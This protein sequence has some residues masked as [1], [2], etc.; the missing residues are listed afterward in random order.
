MMDEQQDVLQGGESLLGAEVKCLQL[1]QQ[2]FNEGENSTVLIANTYWLRIM[3]AC[4]ESSPAP[5][6]PEALPAEG[7]HIDLTEDLAQQLEDII[8]TYQAAEIPAE[9]EDAEEVTAVKEA[10]ARKDQKL[11]KKMLKNLG[12]EAM[13]LMQSLNKLNTP[14][15]KLEAIIKK[16]AELLEEHRSDQKQLKV[17]QKKLLQVMKEKDQLQSEHSRAVLARSKLEGLCR[18]LQRHNKTL[19]EETLQRCR[20]DDL[21]R[22]EIT[23][24][25]QGTLSEIQAQIEEH[26]SRNTKLC[27]ENSALAEKLKGLISQYDQREAPV[28]PEQENETALGV[29]AT[30]KFTEIVFQNLEKVFKH[31]DLK[32]KLL[33]T[34]L[35][36]AN[37]ILKEAEEKH[38]LEKELLLKQTVEYKSQVKVMKE[39]EINM[40]TQLDMYSKKFDEFQ[41]TVSK[42]N[43]VYSSFKQDMDK[44]AKK[45]K[46][47]EKECQSW[48]TR[49]DGCNKSLID[50]VADKAIKEKEFELI[51]IKNQKLENLCRALQEE[52]KSL[53]EKVQGAGSPPDS[54]AT[55]ST[56]K[57]GPKEPESLTVTKEAPASAAPAGTPT[58]ETPLTRELAKLKTE[59]ALLKEIASSF[60]ISH[61]VPTETV[62]S[63]SQGLSE[64]A[65]EP[66]ENHIEESNGGER[67][68]EDN[69]DGVDFERKQRSFLSTGLISS[70]ISRETIKVQWDAFLQLLDDKLQL[71]AEILDG[72]HQSKCISPDTSLID[73]RTG[74]VVTLEKYLGKGKKILLVLIRQFSCLL[75]RLHLKDLEKNQRSLDTRSVQVVVVSFGCQEGAAHWLQET[76][77]RYEM[78]LDPDRK[79]YAAFGLGASLKKVLNFSNM[80]LYAEYVVDNMEFPRGLPSVQDDMFQFSLVCKKSWLADLNQVFLACGLFTFHVDYLADRC[81]GH[82]VTTTRCCSLFDFYTGFVEKERGQPS[83]YLNLEFYGVMRF[84]FEDHVGGNVATKCLRIC[85]SAST[86]EVIESLSE[87]FRPDMKMLTTS[88]SLYEIHASKER[89]LDLHERPLVVQLNWNTDN[90]EGRF[91]LKKDKE[92]LERQQAIAGALA[93]WMANSSELLN[94][95]KHDRDLSSLTQQSQL[96]LSHLVHK[97]YSCLLQCLQNELRKHLPTFLIDPEQYGRLPAG[98]E[99]VLNA[100]MNTMSL[101]RRCRV[102]PALTIQLFSQLFH[103]ISAWLFNRLMSP[104]ADAPGLRSHYWGAALRQRLTAIEAWAERQGLELAAD[105]H[106]GHIIQATMLL[107]MNKYSIQDAKAIQNTCFKLNSLQLQTLLVGYLYAPNEPHIPPDLIDAV[108]TAAEASA[109]NLIRSE[110]RDIQQE[111]S[112]DLHLPFLLPEGGYSCDTAEHREPEVVTI[113]LNKPLNSGMGVSI[114]AAKGAGKGN[115]GIYIK[116]IVKGGPAEMVAKFG[117]SYHGL[118]ALLSEPTPERTTGDKSH[119]KPNS[120][121]LVLYSAVDLGPSEQLHGSS[122]RKKDQIMQRN[123]QL[124]RSNPNMNN[125]SPEDGDEPADPVMRGNNITAV[126][127]INLCTD[128][129]ALSQENLCMDSG[130]PLLDKRQDLWKQR[131][132][133]AKQTMSDYSTFPVRSSV[134]THDILSDT[135]SPTKQQQG[136]RTSGAGVWR[137]PFSQHPTPTPSIQPIRIDIPVTRAVNPQMNPPLTTFQTPA[138]MAVKMSQTLKVNGSPQ[139]QANHIYLLNATKKLSQPSFLSQQHRSTTHGDQ[140]AKPQVSI[141]PTKHVSFQE[142]PTQQHKQVTGPTKL[143]DPQGLSDPWRREA[144]EQLEK[145]QRLYVV[146]LLEQEVQELQAKAKRTAEESDRLRKLSLEW[147][148]QKRLREIQQR[149][150]DEDE[151]E[152]EDLDMMVTIQQ[153]ENRTQARRHTG[154]ENKRSSDGNVNTESN[155]L[156][157][158]TGTHLSQKEDTAE[159]DQRP[160]GQDVNNMASKEN[161]GE[162]MKR[163]SAPEKLTFKERQRLFSL[164]SSA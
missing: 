49:F 89:K 120:K 50:M 146:E 43:S 116:S 115:L 95:F 97:A 1:T 161:E 81:R 5:A 77:C 60:T 149:G 155:D 18:E 130:G 75:C 119:S 96:D 37:M 107:T 85:S 9:P 36:Q 41:G 58:L 53:Y 104:E 45:M 35:T 135:C 136:G 113:T 160:S 141:P 71:G 154:I 51:T 57:E 108:V 112:L 139:N 80:L 128:R 137:T 32:E 79:I 132:Q 52:R 56:E 54:N 133:H 14:E 150:E 48:K 28:L 30:H 64:G 114:V 125:F 65:Q 82:A 99:M 102:N 76:G 158:Q 6:G 40:K 59:Q 100:L 157:R 138:L 164:V 118:G 159:T 72:N 98:I 90:R 29:K 38:K 123:R 144:Q 22:K 124:Y 105:C 110:G 162:E 62:V 163:A 25:F 78:L 3:E 70:V 88:Y 10:D 15:Q 84:C 109:D 87:K 74:E 24:H 66:E 151:E 47:L 21:K 126:S 42:S 17:L 8:S 16:H 4:Q 33:E 27:Q 127:S 23:T 44:M 11:E 69:K 63:E 156:D 143:K 117:A 61:V 20:E 122:K 26:S 140:A 13:L 94:F 148:F 73:A 19:K 92:S 86:R 121:G 142:P 7:Q 101:L 131:D 91:V 103:F 31:R 12:K 152:D 68:Q 134:S 39:Q 147:Q 67:L 106:L 111:E 2:R 83:V 34:K 153:L 129:Q 55:E 93:F 46:K 145:Q